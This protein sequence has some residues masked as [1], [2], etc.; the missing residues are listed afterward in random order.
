[1]DDVDKV[2]LKGTPKVV[3]SVNSLARQSLVQQT[4]VAAGWPFDMWGNDLMVKFPKSKNILEYLIVSVDY[5]S[6]WI[7]AKPLAN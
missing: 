5:F 4:P 1:M 2:M 6:K 3:K 7:E